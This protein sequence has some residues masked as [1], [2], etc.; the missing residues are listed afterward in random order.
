MLFFVSVGMLFDPA[1]LVEHPGKAAVTAVIMVGK[2]LAAIALVLLFGYGLP[3]ALTV[4]VSL[5][6]IGEFSFI[7]AGLGVTLKLLP[8]EGQSLILAGALISISLNRCCSP[9]S[10][11]SRGRWRAVSGA[12][13]SSAR[14][15]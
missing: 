6:Q 7:L 13:T 4:G 12:R 1:V 2:T 9:P 5:A 8:P 11:R 10:A 15:R 14:C 3:T